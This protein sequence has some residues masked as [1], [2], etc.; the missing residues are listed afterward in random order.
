MKK[1][2]IYEYIKERGQLMFP[3]E[4]TWVDFNI[5]GNA[6]VVRYMDIRKLEVF[7]HTEDWNSG[8][9]VRSS[10]GQRCSE[11]YKNYFVTESINEVFFVINQ[12][13]GIYEDD[14]FE[15]IYENT[16]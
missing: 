14:Q 2:D 1:Q 5:E 4:D 6:L 15:W 16:P 7:A 11:V 13:F 10:R 3:P 9:I 8:L 12:E